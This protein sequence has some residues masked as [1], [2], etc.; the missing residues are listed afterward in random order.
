MNAHQQCAAG[1]LAALLALASSAAVADH[2]R[3][4]DRD[5]KKRVTVDCNRGQTIARALT[6][7][8]ED[9]P[10][11]V[12]I[13]GT[14]NEHVLIDRSD[15]TLRGDAGFGGAING[16]D[17]VLDT[18]T[19]SANR[20]AIEG[21]TVSGGQNG[22]RALGAGALTISGSTVRS[23]ARSGIVVIAS[24]GAV[25]DQ[26]TVELNGR[27]GLAAEGSSVTVINSIVS[28]NSRFG[29][30]IGTGAAARIGVDN[31]NLA[32]ASTISQNGASGVSIIIGGAA[33]IANS[34]ITLN[35]TDPTTT[36]G[37]TGISITQATAELIGNNTVADN[38]GQGIFMRSA[39]ANLG[40]PALG[41]ST[42]NAITGNGTALPGSGGILAV[43]GSALQIRDAVISNNRGAGLGLNLRS[44]ATLATSQIENN[45]GEGIRLS[46]GAALQ[47]LFPPSIVAG[48]TGPQLAC[49]DGES[50]VV[51]IA[52]LGL[53]PVV[54]VPGVPILP[55]NCTGFEN[56]Q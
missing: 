55:P 1:L 39:T 52:G 48:N 22:I 2:D 46:L 3:D 53:P 49:F 16:P 40:N 24:S 6:R 12:V 50:S 28:R 41:F 11:L 27:D 5:H 8:D 25:V 15:V 9:L 47:A 34:Q 21:L 31:S 44:H 29:V 56:L 4:R 10:L 43:L 36:S 33:V 37:R 19:V 38:A 23:T 13:R 54:P 35:G 42:V 7:G 17:P 18:I 20:V 51:N 30:F 45:I 14:C 32:A 26:S